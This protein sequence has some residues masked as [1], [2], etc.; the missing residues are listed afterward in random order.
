MDFSKL[1]EEFYKDVAAKRDTLDK[2]DQGPDREKRFSEKIMG[3]PVVKKVQRV[4]EVKE[5]NEEEKEEKEEVKEERGSE[6]DEE[7]EEKDERRLSREAS[8]TGSEKIDLGE[9]EEADGAASVESPDY[10]GIKFPFPEQTDPSMCRDEFIQSILM[11]QE[12]KY[13]EMKRRTTASK[14]GASLEMPKSVYTVSGDENP[15]ALILTVLRKFRSSLFH[16]GLSLKRSTSF[17]RKSSVWP[18]S[19]LLM[20]LNRDVQKAAIE[21]LSVRVLKQLRLFTSPWPGEVKDIPYFLF[22]WSLEYFE[23]RLYMNQLYLDVIQRER[24]K[25]DLD[26]V[27]FRTD[28]VEIANII[29]DIRDEFAHDKNL[30]D[31]VYLILRNAMYH[32]NAPWI[33]GLKEKQKERDQLS[34]HKMVQS[35][36]SAYFMVARETTILDRFENS[37]AYDPIELRYR[38]NWLN[39]CA[40]QRLYRFQMREEALKTE[41]EELTNQMNLDTMVQNNMEFMYGHEIDKAKRKIQE[42]TVRYDNDLE[43]AEVAVQMTRLAL[44]KYKD[45]FK[46]YQEQEEMYKRRIAE[47]RAL[48]ATEAKIRQDK[49]AKATQQVVDVAETVKAIEAVYKPPPP[50]KA[51]KKAAKS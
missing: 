5:E 44:Q 10:M 7:M 27:K 1:Q 41:L 12:Q 42:W 26:C 2:K 34:R 18:R 19:T 31:H 50:K 14:K 47:E 49:Q 20:N 15:E 8:P 6:T 40:D 22:H 39:S 45:D 35:S 13:S 23:S 51:K 29:Y 9:E 43:N 28:L 32:Q 30:C 25:E 3:K 24:T 17:R 38:V 11:E 4:E 16:T 33:Q 21:F 46:F 37:A 36:S 48:M